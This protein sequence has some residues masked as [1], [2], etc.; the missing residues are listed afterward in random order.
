[1]AGFGRLSRV[2]QRTRKKSSSSRRW[3]IK[4]KKP[5]TPTSGS[6]VDTQS[7]LNLNDKTKVETAVVPSG[8]ESGV[9]LYVLG[10]IVHQCQHRISQIWSG[11]WNVFLFWRAYSQRV[12]ILHQKV[13][14]LQRELQ[15]LQSNGVVNGPRG[16]CC[17]C[18][19][20]RDSPVLQQHQQSSVDPLTALPPPP[21]PPPPSLPPPPPPLPPAKK[22]PQKLSLIPKK[23]TILTAV[24]EKIDRRVAV[25]LKDLQA[26][27]LRKVT[28]NRKV[29]VSP[30]K[31][32]VPL[33][34]LADLQ[35]VRLKRT[36]YRVP[37]PLRPS[38]AR[39]PNKSPVKLRAHLKKVHIN[40]TPGRSPLCNKENLE[41]LFR[42][43][44]EN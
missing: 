33:I 1:M 26:V 37:S 35:K 6:P 43:A 21:P 15:L 19:L 44:I 4:T 25:T 32:Q 36:Q 16:S 10:G 18:V 30:E 20:S 29:L 28:V 9:F 11:F 14:S 2:F 39:S 31:K 22:T 3:A 34:T 27:Q 38:L 17:H 42:S 13:D 12:E 41:E 23:R 24:Q 5:T 8:Q 7:K 40:Q